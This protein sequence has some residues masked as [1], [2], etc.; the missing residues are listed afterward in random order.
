LE[1]A[2]VAA[3]T[4]GEIASIWE[5]QFGAL[6]LAP[7][8]LALAVP[9]AAVGAGLLAALR[10]PERRA[11]V[12]LAAAVGPLAA[13]TAFGV[14]KGR[15]FEA[16]GVRVFFV[17]AVAAGAGACAYALTGPLRRLLVT[18]P[19]ALSALAAAVIVVLEL[20]NRFALVRLYPAFHAALAAATL[21]VA[22]AL[23]AATEPSTVT[24]RWAVTSALSALVVFA[25]AAVA[26]PAAARLAYF[27]HFRVLLV[28]RAP[29]LGHAVRAAALLAPPAPLVEV[30]GCAGDDCGGRAVGQSA[31]SA[32]P[33]HQTAEND[34]GP[35][36]VGRDIVL[37]TIDALR[38]DHV[39]CYGYT[40]RTTP[41]LD[42]LAREAVV[43]ENAYAPTPHTS[44]SVTSLL[45]GKFMRP[46]LL[47]GAGADSDTLPTLLRTYGYRTGGF[48]PPSV[49]FIDQSRFEPFDKKGFGFEYRKTEFLE[50]KGRVAQVGEYLEKRRNDQRLF[51]WLHLFG[52]H[53]PYEAHPGHDF[54]ERDIDRYD[55]EIAAADE[56][57][58]AVVRRVRSLRPGAVVILTADH[59]EEFGEHGGRY[60]GTTVYEEQ[61]RVPLIISAPGA[62][63]PR[64]IREPV[65][66]IDLTPTLLAALDIPGQPRLRGRNLGPLMTGSRPSGDGFAFA[67]TDDFT[68]LAEASFRLICA[69]KIGACQLFDVS[70]DRAEQHDVSG[71]HR[72]RFLAMR[73]RLRQFVSSHG[74][75]EIAGL[76]AQGR[77]WP[78]A[79]LRGIGGDADAAADVAALLDDADREIRRK[80]AEVLFELRQPSTAPAL[81]LALSRDEDVG[82]RRWSALALTRL[83]EGAPLALDLLADGDRKWRRLAALAFAE[84]GDDRGEA[85]LVDWWM[86]GAVDEHQRALELLQ[87][88]AKLRSKNAVWPLVQS[89]DRVRLRPQIAE[90][91]AAI[92]DDGAR[93]PLARALSGERYQVARIAL[94]RA[95][96]ALGAEGELVRPLVRFLGTPDPL[97]DGLGLALEA[98]ILQHVGGPEP[99]FLRRLRTEAGLGATVRLVVP[100]G[101]HGAGLR[102]LVRAR[103]AGRPGEV[104]V[105]RPAKPVMNSSKSA[106]KRPRNVPRI[107]DERQVG[108]RVPASGVFV[109][110]HVPVPDALELRPGLSVD[111]V[112][113]AEQHVE[114]DALAI[115]PLE[116]ELPPP[117]PEP[118]SADSPVGQP[119][120]EHR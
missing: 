18:R 44:Y 31:R 25:L 104:R 1:L 65:Q 98:G 107:H 116:D 67:E 22:P 84:T 68:M 15:H 49:F 81:R 89:L 119:A 37:I 64:R 2:A 91:L 71:E 76:R 103:S 108:V 56:T 62:L 28:E 10:R 21:T 88:F 115:V 52:P 93:G 113:Y 29:L 114:L 105:G 9:F 106:R 13:L 61:V 26:R 109:E 72:E 57:V 48:Y 80:A 51:I 47:Q 100:R 12:V 55:S 34:S 92:G 35:S 42:A 111:L 63:R 36:L 4:R 24:R 112:A 83:G 30:D 87:A 85:L 59:G 117:A 16:V 99:A 78:E 79:I 8:A 101:G 33:A 77:G 54:G 74:R 120:A 20:T 90:A 19:A 5:L 43:F 14:S 82:V 46:L 41:N 27:D 70:R 118:W 75:F 7:T 6:W 40:R 45:T 39:G 96:V 102:L 58:G 38:A 11:R 53:E 66:T 69:R 94:A 60:H 32:A 3:A 110:R 73:E 97:P 86:H 50:G 95:L 23:L 17:A